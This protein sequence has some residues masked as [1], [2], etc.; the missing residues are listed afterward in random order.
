MSPKENVAKFVEAADLFEPISGQ[1]P[2]VDIT[3]ICET[4][5]PILLQIPY[6]KDEVLDNLVGII[7]VEEKYSAKYGKPS[8]HQNEWERT[9]SCSPTTQSQSFEQKGKRDGGQKGS[10]VPPTKQH[11][12]KQRAS[13]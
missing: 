8:N 6:D 10:I 5:T 13:S 11:I 9:M 1:P 3:L 7:L 2:D 4:L 12:R